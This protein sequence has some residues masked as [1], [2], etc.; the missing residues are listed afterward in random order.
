MASGHFI[1]DGLE[2]IRLSN[3]GRCQFKHLDAATCDAYP[4]GIPLAML[5]GQNQHNQ[6]STGDNG[7]QFKP[8]NDTRNKDD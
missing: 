3:C 2:I 8:L 1:T 4:T 7:I 6:P 5:S